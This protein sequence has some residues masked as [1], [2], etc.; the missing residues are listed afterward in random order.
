MKKIILLVNTLLILGIGATF[1]QNSGTLRATLQDS[2]SGEGINGAVI[3]LT[4]TANGK[5]QYY[6]SGHQGKIS[7]TSLAPATYDMVISYLGYKDYKRQ[8]KVKAGDNNLGIIKFEEDA[9]IIDQVQ[10]S[11]FLG[12][13]TKGDTISYNA[14]AFK[15]VK[16][17]SAEGLLSKM[18][19]I[20]VGSD[21]SVNAQ[22][23]T[24]Q[25]V[26]VDGKEFF[27]E[28]VSTTIKTIPAEMV[29]KVEV[30]DK[31][32]D[33]AEF[34]GLD[35]G[36]GYKA[37]NIV[38]TLGKRRGVFGKVYGSYGY[39]DKYS[40]GGNANIFN[41]DEKISIIAMANNINQLNFSFEDIVGASANNNV[42]SS[43]GGGGMRG[44]GGMGQARNFMVRPMAGISTVQSVGLNYANQWDKLE[45]QS[46]YFFNHSG[47]VNK[48]ITDKTL[49]SSGSYKE[50]SLSNTDSESENWNHRLNLRLDYKFS[51]TSSLMVRANA[52]LQQYDNATLGSEI[53][54]NADTE[55]VLKDMT[56]ERND[57]RTGTYG[58]IFVLYRTR[59]AKPGRTIT[60]NSRVNWNSSN[61]LNIPSYIFDRTPVDSLYKNII[62]NVSGSNSVRAEA[63]YTEPL[64]KNTQMDFEYEFQHNMN[65]QNKTA[66]VFIDN[67][68]NGA[69]GEL[70]SN[71][72]ESGY[73][74]QRIGPGFNYSTEKT[75]FNFQLRYQYSSLSN[76]QTLPRPLLQDYK[77]HDFTYRGNLTVNFNPTNALR[78]RL[79][80]RTQNPS[81]NQLQD[82]VDVNGTSYS[83]GNPN[84]KPS[85]S[86]SLMMFYTNTNI[87]KGQT[88]MLHGGMWAT[89]R[90]IS[91]A[92][93]MNNP[94]FVIPNY[95]N[96][97][98]G[99]GNTYS[100]YEN[101]SGFNNWNIFSGVSFGFPLPFIKSNITLSLNG[102]FNS[103][104]S[105][106]NDHLNIM[107]GQYYSSGV[108]IGSN[109]SENLD[110]TLAYN[111]S[112]SIN[113]NSSDI[114]SQLNKYLSHNVRADFK[115]VAWKGFTLTANAT[116][117]QYKGITDNYNEEI[118]L[119]NA[120][121]GK[122]LFKD[123][124][125]ELSIGVNDIFNQNRDFRRSVGANY[126]QNTTNLAI[127]RYVAVQFVYNIRAYGKGSS[128]KDFDNMGMGG[129]HGNRGGFG[130]GHR[131]MG[132]PPMR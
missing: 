7:I 50:H 5:Q 63:T 110:F 17:A 105:K 80:S 112:Y 104:P 2:K 113:D 28:D 18:P 78:V 57:E 83:A 93:Q 8:V 66:R 124:R 118:L 114:Y 82:A 123:E 35:D 85:Y 122:K 46:S 95:N 9:T 74:T 56:S 6:T 52:S 39:P 68:E 67:V 24:V 20:T 72:S 94:D 125:G 90:S 21:G 40:V 27:G 30:Y 119:C 131:P 106:I 102:N 64:G 13:S 76:E 65:N 70:L 12:T 126:I 16:D 33:K 91:S 132:P 120:Y 22:G 55:E 100:T 129:G 116:Y 121:L 48:N 89:T 86:H 14:S 37:I 77:F 44:G 81:I 101:I 96:Q 31:L 111:F 34:T 84:L 79:N 42:A 103:T 4:S 1:A 97:T 88:L 62:E 69:L 130:G 58:N 11:G 109:V 10:I 43:G 115:W 15:T 25:K 32:S 107:R 73:T 92:M 41:G 45:L 108:Q 51:K 49:F 53:I 47:T 54:K 87:E 117:N 23:E 75:K 38:T 71:I 127:G 60:V 36:E 61:S 19:G 26:F 128:A 3:E 59:L 98:L 99:V 29:S